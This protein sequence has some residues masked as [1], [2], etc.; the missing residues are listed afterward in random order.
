MR[1]LALTGV[2]SRSTCTCIPAVKARP[3]PVMTAARTVSS[4]ASCSTAARSSAMSS[5]TMRLS[6]A[7]SRVIQAAP[8]R[9]SMRTKAPTTART[10]G[11]GRLPPSEP[12][13]RIPLRGRSPRTERNICVPN[14]RSRASCAPSPTA[15]S[16]P[17]HRRV[18]GARPG[19]EPAREVADVLEA[20]TAQILGH[21]GA[22]HALMAVDDG[23]RRGVELAGAQL[24]LLDGDVEGV[25]QTAETGLPVLADIEEHQ[26]IGLPQTCLQL[27]R[28][29]L[30]AHGLVSSAPH[31]ITPH[32]DR[33]GAGSTSP[34]RPPL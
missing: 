17:A 21:G 25:L 20:E 2:R 33:R 32:V 13:P 8:C 24:D 11:G 28:R 14:G 1:A 19:V 6:G 31:H 15:S 9:S 29:E 4:R 34:A 12:A 7:R 30:G 23:L 10:L 27:G 5:G 3:A 22:A 18:D 26:R 16:V